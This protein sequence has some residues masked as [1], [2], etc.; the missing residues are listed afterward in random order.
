MGRQ[1][2][3]DVVVP[4]EQVSRRHAEI[5]ERNGGLVV[6]DLGSSNGTFVNGTRISSSQ[7][8]MPGD[9][10]QVGTTV[11]KVVG[12]PSVGGA[13][14]YDQAA[15][16]VSGYNPGGQPSGQDY[17]AYGSPAAPSAP[18]AN[19]YGQPGGYGQPSGGYG[20]SPAYGGSGSSYD[21]GQNA[22]GGGSSSSAAPSYGGGAGSSYDQGQNAYGGSQ[23]AGGYGGSGSSY[24][25]GQN[26]YGSPAGGNAYGG[27]ASA[28]PS[29]GGAGSSYDPAN[30][31]AGAYGG[32]QGGYGQGQQASQSPYGQSGASYD[33]ANPSAGAYGGGQGQGSY[34]PAN[35]GAGAYGQQ[36]GYNQG[37]Q[38]YGGQQQGQYSPGGYPQPAAAAPAKKGGFPLPILI[39]GIVVV[40]VILGVLAFFLFF[41]K[42]GGTSIGSDIPAP[43]NSTKLDVSAQDIAKIDPTANQQDISKVNYGF[44]ASTDSP[45]TILSFYQTELK[46]RGWTQDTTQSDTTGAL[47]KKGDN[48]TGIAVV[49]MTTQNIVTGFETAI[50]ALKGKVKVGQTLVIVAS[51]PSS[52][53]KTTPG[54]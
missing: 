24:D 21:Q 13:A 33:P 11:L 6:T 30:P 50:P 10:V 9:T 25:Q 16:Q 32:Q 17:G 53:F 47:F 19:D 29:Y 2:G 35:P 5:E 36:G 40:L 44:F 22:Y 4:D 42:G 20:Q 28:A 54:A 46:N 23:G 49:P 39:I 52:V 14:D 15:T 26:A 12:S 34:D 31:G 7:T 38:A 3:N 37:Q 8:L 1:S 41:N 45:A 18:S 43:P 27:G 51:G 48:N